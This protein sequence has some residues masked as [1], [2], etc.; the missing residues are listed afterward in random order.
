MGGE[1]S[2]I[3]WEGRLAPIHYFF[4]FLRWLGGGRGPCLRSREIDEVNGVA[5][6]LA[7]TIDLTH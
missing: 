4:W 1:V 7:G 6:R 2:G 5:R 3:M